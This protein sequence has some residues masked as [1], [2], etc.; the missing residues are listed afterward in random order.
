M[1]AK[2]LYTRD[3]GKFQHIYCGYKGII[4]PGIMFC[5]NDGY[6]RWVKNHH[7]FEYNVFAI[8][9][10]FVILEAGSSKMRVKAEDVEIVPVEQREEV[11]MFISQSVS[12][13]RV[14]P[15][16]EMLDFLGGNHASW[17]AI[18]AKRVYYINR[19]PTK[20]GYGTYR[21][22]DGQ[23]CRIADDYDSSD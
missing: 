14:I 23:W 6:S 11:L 12:S 18:P 2:D 20:W 15:D 16:E 10:E 17:N 8:H 21:K 9:P 22:E 4:E 7:H 1:K 3:D 19:P 5:W 13:Q